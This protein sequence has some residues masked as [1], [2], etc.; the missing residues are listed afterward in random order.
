VGRFSESLIDWS[1]FSVCKLG[2]KPP[3]PRALSTK[4]GLGDRLRFVAF[5][6]KQAT[7]AFDLASKI[8]DVPERVRKVWQ[9]L[10]KEEEKHLNWLLY[11]MKEL[12][13]SADERPQGLA[14]WQSF[15]RC[16]TPTQFANFMANAED[17]GRIAGEQFYQTLL[18]I[19]PQTAR[20]FQQIA[21]EEVEHIRLASAVL[22]FNFAIPADF[23]F[24]VEGL[25]LEDYSRI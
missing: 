21:K 4:E 14:L 17:R 15:D 2:E 7:H 19:D 13:V 23:S 5:A 16:E 25:P 8:Y 1:P 22:E 20:L 10:S 24:Q 9:T 6:E 11:R 12:G 3:Y 18:A